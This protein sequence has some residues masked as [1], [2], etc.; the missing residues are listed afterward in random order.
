MR[1]KTDNFQPGAYFH[2]YNRA[3]ND[4][5]IFHNKEDYILLLKKLKS[6]TKKIPTT[7][8]AYCLMPNHFHFLIRQDDEIPAYKIFNNLFSYYVQMFNKK[9]NRKGR[10]FQGK[11]QHKLVT[12][13]KYLIYLCQYIHNNPLKANI[14]KRL[15]D[16]EFSNYLE[17][18][19]SRNGTLFDNELLQTY[20]IN[21]NNYADSIKEYEQHIKDKEFVDILMD[22]Y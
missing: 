4:E 6:V 9:Y 21:A 3:I 13:E 10:L 16:W 12:N 20:F 1:C 11:L 14:V 18:I 22:Y 19:G 5:R 17:W 7:I 8:F 15:E 2:F